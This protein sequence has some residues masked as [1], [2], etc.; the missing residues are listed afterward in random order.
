MPIA[1]RKSLAIL[2]GGCAGLSLARQLAVMN[3][4][5][6]EGLDI[7]ILD[8]A[9]PDDR[10]DHS[11]GFWAIP[12]T[13][14]AFA[15]ARK[16]WAQWQIITS[17]G[18]AVQTADQHPYASLEAKAWLTE[19]RRLTQNSN[20]RM[21][22]AAVHDLT[23]DP[24]GY[25]M[26]TSIGEARADMIIDSRSPA[27]AKN[28]MLQH[29]IGW[30]VETTTECFDP[31][32]ATLMDFR[33]DQSR[34]VHFIYVLP[35]S[36]RRALVESTLFTPQTEADDYYE[37]AIDQYIQEVLGSGKYM[38]LRR[39]RGVIPMARIKPLAPHVT[40]IGANGG[41]IRPASGYAFPFIQKQVA[42]LTDELTRSAT[43]PRGA[44]V[45]HQPVDLWM[46]DIF[47]SVLRHQPAL[48]PK[49]FLA[50]A[51]ALSGD[52]MARFLSGMADARLRA[53][54]IMAM[55]KL[56]FLRALLRK[57]ASL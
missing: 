42:I 25:Y 23:R 34:G 37:T 56:P 57:R 14:D 39:E 13:A 22:K 27:P 48:A 46:D 8:A 50:M 18:K 21:V 26:N 11:W 31:E 45:P 10:A 35:F 43:L 3:S 28:I 1:D 2:G 52:E 38:I 24:S 15:M 32:T 17:T 41:A 40:A 20:I 5:L 53:K 30:E 4:S 16:T 55:P 6:Q 51:N 29:F 19:A 49:I 33:C 7:A 44:V 12:E 47:L 54:I 9:D 36:N